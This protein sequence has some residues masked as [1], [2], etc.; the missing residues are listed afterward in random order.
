M[1]VT[2]LTQLDIETANRL[3]REAEAKSLRI[4][5]ALRA[6][7]EEHFARQDRRE[8]KQQAQQNTSGQTP[9]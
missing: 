2:V 8:Q 3:H 1:R 4:S 6:I 5:P 9:A 7:V